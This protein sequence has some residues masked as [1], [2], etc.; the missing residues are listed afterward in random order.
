[1]SF[2]MEQFI[3]LTP[4]ELALGFAASCIEGASRRLGVPCQEVAQRM[5]RI[6][7]VEDYILPFYEELHSQSR[8][9][10]TDHIIEYLINKE[11]GS[12]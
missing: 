8:E 1:M 12:A 2:A 11:R 10:V 6:N 4:T 9:H 7:M 3:H 5:A